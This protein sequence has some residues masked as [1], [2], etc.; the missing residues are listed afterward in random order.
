[1]FLYPIGY[2]SSQ[3]F[4]RAL[5]YASSGRQFV[6]QRAQPP[7]GS[8]YCHPQTDCFVLSELFSVANHFSLSIF[9]HSVWEGFESFGAV[10]R[11]CSKDVTITICHSKPS[12]RKWG[13]SVDDVMPRRDN[14]EN[15][16]ILK[17]RLLGYLLF[18]DFDR[19]R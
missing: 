5:H 8:I 3:F 1:M 7:W 14:S 16:R 15:L 2:Q 10:L 19:Q 12:E 18:S 17:R 13:W 9:Y 11:S 4:R 6:R